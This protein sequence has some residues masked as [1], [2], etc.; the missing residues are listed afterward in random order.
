[1]KE[2]NHVRDLEAIFKVL[3]HYGIKPNLRGY[4]FGVKFRIFL[5]Y[6]IDLGGIL[7]QILTRLNYAGY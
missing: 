7:R 5:S 3:K 4:T 2:V 6:V 1:V